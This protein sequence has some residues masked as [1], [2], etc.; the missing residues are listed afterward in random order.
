MDLQPYLDPARGMEG[1]PLGADARLLAL[2]SPPLYTPFPNPF[3]EDFLSQAPRL[4]VFAS[5][6]YSREPMAADISEGRT[7]PAYLAQNYHTKV[8]Y[9]AIARYLEHFTDP[10]DL[11]LDGFCGSGMVG[12]AANQTGRRALLC[13]L[14]PAAT[15]L[16]H[17]YCHP[18]DLAEASEAFS[19]VLRQL[20]LECGWLYRVAG[21]TQQA[22]GT[23]DEENP[24][25]RTQ[26]PEPTPALSAPHSG[27]IREIDYVLWSE[28]FGCPRCSAEFP[29]SEAGFDFERRRPLREIRCPSCGATLRP[30]D[31]VRSLDPTGRTREVPVRVAHVGARRPREAMPEPAFFE[32]QRAIEGR[33]I[34][35][36]YP[37]YPMMNRSGLGNG[38]GDMWRR[39]YHSGME[40]VS[41]FYFKRTLWALATAVQL[42]QRSGASRSSQQLMLQVIVN[43][44]TSLTRMRRAYQGVLPLVLYVPRL[45]R[46]VNVPRALAARFRTLVACLRQLRTGNGVLISTQSA[47]S[48]SNV[49]D[50]CVDYI[51]TDPPFGDNIRYSEVNFLWEAWLGVFTNQGPEAIISAGQGKDV[52]E[53]Q[54]LMR[55][56]FA[57]MHRVLKPGRWITVAFHNSES[58]VWNAVQEALREAGFEVADVRLLDKRQVSFKQASANTV[59][60]DLVISGR[61]EAWSAKGTMRSTEG[62]VSDTGS[63][64]HSA[65]RTTHRGK[66]T[67]HS[68]LAAGAWEFVRQRLRQL[69]I[70]APGDEK[71]NAATER[72]DLALFNQMVAAHLRQGAQV[73]LDAQQFR[74]GLSEQFEE[75]DGMYFLPDQAEAYDRLVASSKRTI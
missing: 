65:L 29:F 52:D 6:A 49:P 7:D 75:R 15:F 38:W 2:A 44:S 19:E 55:R 20:E 47:T 74:S 70:P 63:S 21:R 37:D 33:P 18:V 62:T 22:Q 34:P 11:V 40:K 59:R 32:L 1:C 8:P 4:P 58:R 72:G 27:L 51:F 39:G 3:V 23:R 35:H 60:R 16:A 64:V 56:C 66:A 10:G 36:R 41:D 31:L 26:N 12:V 73:P 61:R 42:V 5:P 54:E 24:E 48:L 25:L 50:G 17:S 9:R 53:Y 57:E 68:G 67:S 46:E 13:D 14:S 30:H 71:S 28:V 45:K 69:P 43:S